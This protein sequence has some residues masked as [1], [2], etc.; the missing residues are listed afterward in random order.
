[1]LGELAV[2]LNQNCSYEIRNTERKQTH[3]K[4]LVSGTLAHLYILFSV[5]YSRVVLCCI[6]RE[7]FV[8]SDPTR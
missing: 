1:M 4:L 8:A 7:T 3:C 2:Q 6:N 5:A